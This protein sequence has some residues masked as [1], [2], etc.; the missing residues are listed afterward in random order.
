MRSVRLPL[1]ALAAL[2][3]LAACSSDA[4]APEVLTEA[5]GEA[6]RVLRPT[7]PAYQNGSLF[8]SG[9]RAA[10]DSVAAPVVAVFTMP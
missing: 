1:M 4:T 6:T 7:G 3:S 2:A 5:P 10:S 8:G 9:A